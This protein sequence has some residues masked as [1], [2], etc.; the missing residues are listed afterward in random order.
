MSSESASL[1][2]GME[3]KGT[4]GTRPD[5][6]C[7]RWGAPAEE[8][9]PNNSENP[10]SIYICPFC[11]CLLNPTHYDTCTHFQGS[12]GWSQGYSQRSVHMFISQVQGI[13][14]VGNVRVRVYDGVRI[15]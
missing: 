2:M 10:P 9:A 14:Q 7:N 8:D 12:R 13:V 3:W 6:R 4:L 11:L 5:E 15:L 1:G